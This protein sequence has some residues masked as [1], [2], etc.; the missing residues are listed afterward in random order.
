[1]FFSNNLLAKDEVNSIYAYSL[2]QCL[3]VNN[4]NL[5]YDYSYFDFDFVKKDMLNFKELSDLNSFIK[6]KTSSFQDEIE[7]IRSDNNNKKVNKIFYKC[8]D[9]H[10]S[11]KLKKYISDRFK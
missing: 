9:F 8:Y 5:N 2:M 11:D 6:S 7:I 3:E 1:M 10:N 4:Y